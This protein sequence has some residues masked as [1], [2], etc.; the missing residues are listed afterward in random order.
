MTWID[1]AWFFVILGC[2]GASVAAFMVGVTW[3]AIEGVK[4][5]VGSAQRASEKRSN[6]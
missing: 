1:V 2:I 6:F 3:L 4:R 5:W